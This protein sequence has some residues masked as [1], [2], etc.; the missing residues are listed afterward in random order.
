MIKGILLIITEFIA[1]EWSGKGVRD[2]MGKREEKIKGPLL[3]WHGP[4]GLNPV[5]VRSIK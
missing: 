5:L 2:E 3:I 1:D 4:R